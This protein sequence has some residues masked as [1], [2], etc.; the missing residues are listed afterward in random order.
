MLTEDGRWLTLEIDWVTGSHRK[1]PQ[2]RQ[3]PPPPPVMERMKVT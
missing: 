3:A 1:P 2:L